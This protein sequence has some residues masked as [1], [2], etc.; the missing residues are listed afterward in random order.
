MSRW[1]AGMTTLLAPGHLGPG[2][3]ERKTDCQVARALRVALEIRTSKWTHALL[4]VKNLSFSV[5][6]L[7]PPRTGTI[8]YYISSSRIHQQKWLPMCRPALGEPV[9]RAQ[10]SSQPGEP[11]EHIPL[12]SDCNHTRS[13]PE[14]RARPWACLTLCYTTRIIYIYVPL[15]TVV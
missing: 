14:R 7:N 8:C 5:S 15:Y 1:R 2:D 9:V 6:D 3:L 4:V 11:V 12:P 13:T 10:Q